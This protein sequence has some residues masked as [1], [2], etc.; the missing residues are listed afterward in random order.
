MQRG[1][2]LLQ[3]HSFFRILRYIAL[4]IRHTV[5]T[6]C[7]EA[8]RLLGPGRQSRNIAKSATSGPYGRALGLGHLGIWVTLV[9]FSGF[10]WL[11]VHSGSILMHFG[12]LVPHFGAVLMHFWCIFDEFCWSVWWILV[13]FWCILMDFDGFW[14]IS[15]DFGAF[16]LHFDAFW[17]SV[18]AL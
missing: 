7:W 17:C 4:K 5:D 13:C 15:M 18:D 6:G 16:W 9:D 12:A 1:Q 11:V 2:Y 10:W 8:Q 3:F 14:W